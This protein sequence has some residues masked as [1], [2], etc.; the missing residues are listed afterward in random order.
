[1]LELAHLYDYEVVLRYSNEDFMKIAMMVRGY[2]TAPRPSDIIYAPIDLAVD[3]SDGLAQR[4]HDVTLFAPNG[5]HLK[6]ANVETM[7]IRP[8]VNNQ[9]ELNDFFADIGKLSHGLLELWDRYLVLEMFRRAREGEFDLLHFHH[10][11]SALDIANLFPDVPV[12]YTMHDPFTD[13]YREMFDL[14]SSVNQ[15]FV[16]ISDDQRRQAPDVQFVDTVYNGIDPEIFNVGEEHED[17]LIIAGRIVPE[18]GIKE[19]I[20]IARATDTRLFIIGPV[21]PDQQDYFDQ[22]IKPELDDKILYLGYMEKEQL[23]K[24]YQKAK[25]FIAPIQWEEPFGLTFIES[26]A[27]GAPVIALNR[28]SVSEIIKH[29]KNGFICNNI[30]DMI[31]AVNKVES[32]DRMYCRRYVERNFAIKNMVDGYEKVFEKIIAGKKSS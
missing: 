16:S 19:A 27:C 30:E 21:Y 24:Y 6:Y 8:L 12:V 23:V 10:P 18:K 9:E 4:G 28:G 7:N 13:W 31:D 25:A 20:Q 22:Y 11:E 5:S 3:I 15:S 14:F 29:E 32:I 17:Y 1:M 2:I 26:M